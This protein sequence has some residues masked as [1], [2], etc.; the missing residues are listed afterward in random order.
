MDATRR[1][2]GIPRRD[3]GAGA[4]SAETAQAHMNAPDYERVASVLVSIGL[5]LVTTGEEVPDA[6]SCVLPGVDGGAGR[7]GFFDRGSGRQ[8]PGV[9]GAA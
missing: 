3:R 4:G 2:H 7:R 5:R 9:C 6:D 8:A 1:A